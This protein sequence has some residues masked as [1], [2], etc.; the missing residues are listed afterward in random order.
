MNSHCLKCGLTESTFRK[1]GKFGCSSCIFV[2]LPESSFSRISSDQ[3]IKLRESE[4]ALK[5]KHKF[6]WKNISFRVRITRCL[7][8][9]FFPY[10]SSEKGS[11][12]SFLEKKGL[13]LQEG[14]FSESKGL[15][16]TSEQM[17]RF[18]S[19][20]EDHLRYE[21]I[22]KQDTFDG[23]KQGLDGKFLKILFEKGI[24]AWSPRIGFINSCPTNCGRGDRLSVQARLS[25]SDFSL[26]SDYLTPFLGFGVEFTVLSD[27]RRDG[28]LSSVGVPTQI[29]C[30]N[31]NP[32]QKRRFFKILGL[33]GLA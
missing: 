31:G 32:I 22:W 11:I 19:N 17:E 29:S 2:F 24:W 27:D 10:Y 5:P 23:K 9:G 16:T 18:Y 15:E 30:K 25:P 26:A 20:G 7:R 12:V 28:S 14:E 21:K 33:L 13:A 1:T 8:E 6:D 3:I 4:T